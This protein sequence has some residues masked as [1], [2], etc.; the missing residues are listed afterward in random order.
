MSDKMKW[1]LTPFLGP[2]ETYR[3]STTDY[4]ENQGVDDALNSRFQQALFIES[5]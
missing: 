3:K 4:K 2:V 5:F 1:L